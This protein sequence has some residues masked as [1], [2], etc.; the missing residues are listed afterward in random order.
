MSFEFEVTVTNP[1]LEAPL[2]DVK[3][4]DNRALVG[5]KVTRVNDNTELTWADDGTGHAVLNI[6]SLATQSSLTFRY[7]YTAK[8]T[9]EDTV[10]GNIALVKGIYKTGAGRLR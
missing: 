5:S 8:D 7:T 10:I 9:D 4:Y 2:S 3:L 1:S 6:G